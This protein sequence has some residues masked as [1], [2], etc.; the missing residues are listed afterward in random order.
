MRSSTTADVAGEGPGAAPTTTTG[1]KAH[2]S[3]AQTL[4]VNRARIFTAI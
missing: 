4:R 1:K 3:V 2:T